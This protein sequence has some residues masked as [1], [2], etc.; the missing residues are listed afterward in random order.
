MKP[1]DPR[2]VDHG[3]KATCPGL[4]GSIPKI[5]FECNKAMCMVAFF[6]SF[7]SLVWYNSIGFRLVSRYTNRIKSGL[8]RQR[9]HL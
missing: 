2:S 4:N 3:L 5:Y 8:S 1:R 6:C 9:F 7:M